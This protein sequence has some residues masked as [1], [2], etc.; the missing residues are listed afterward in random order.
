MSYACISRVLAH[1]KQTGNAKLLLVAIAH[2]AHDNGTG[3]TP[4]IA[5]LARI[6]GT[7]ERNVQLLLRKLEQSGELICERGAGPNGCNAYTLCGGDQHFTGE[8]QPRSP[9]VSSDSPARGETAY[10]QRRKERAKEVESTLAPVLGEGR[11]LP[12]PGQPPLP[13]APVELWR[14]ARAELRRTDLHQ[15]QAFASEHDLPTGGHGSYWLGRA[16]LAAAAYDADFATNPRAR[17]LVRAILIRW[18]NQDA[19][20]SDTPTY[21]ASRREQQHDIL[22]SQPGRVAAA[23]RAHPQPSIG[24]GG[25]SRTASGATVACTILGFASDGG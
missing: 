5:T 12:P 20:G 17:N 25:A 23:P 8:T 7:G 2:F 3:A 15:L 18:R 19:Y 11:S 21:Q 4:S 6:I 13:A 14:A 10:T 24:R 1:S 22:R 9:E 16:I